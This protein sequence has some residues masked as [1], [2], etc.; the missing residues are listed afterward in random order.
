VY[1]LAILF[2]RVLTLQYVPVVKN[3]VTLSQ[4]VCSLQG[5]VA[6]DGEVYDL[7][8][9]EHPGG[10]SIKLFGGNDVTVQYRM[11]HPFHAPSMVNKMKRVGRLAQYKCDYTFGSEFEKDLK[12][13]VAKVVKPNQR[14]ATPGFIFR[15]TI[16]I[17]IYAML[18]AYYV[19][20]GSSF[21]L[22]VA[23]G[24]SQATIGLNVQHDANHGSVS[25]NPFWNGTFVHN[26]CEKC[27]FV[28]CVWMH[29]VFFSRSRW[30][31]S[32]WKKNVCCLLSMVWHG[33]FR[34]FWPCMYVCMHAVQG[35]ASDM[36]LIF[37]CV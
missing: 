20:Y 33:I 14:F 35:Y 19:I 36:I 31:L 6:I 21:W 17:S 11:I 28:T 29:K 26:P 13:A 16:Y 4:T 5:Y 1:S 2:G 18:A 22:C 30:H 8:S 10:E 34:A 27:T 15:A 3:S 25:S 23:I 9:F 37:F 12:N 24:V 32:C 7:A